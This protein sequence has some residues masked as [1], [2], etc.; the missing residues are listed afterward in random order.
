MKLARLSLIPLFVTI[1]LINQ[2]WLTVSLTMAKPV[3][4]TGSDA[5]SGLAPLVFATILAVLVAI[6]LNG[7]LSVVLIIASETFLAIAVCLGFSIFFQS[8]P[9]FANNAI[10]KTT[11]IQGWSGQIESVVTSWSFTGWQIGT[12]A[13]IVSTAI[14]LALAGLQIGRNQKVKQNPPQKKQNQAKQPDLWSET[15]Q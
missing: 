13:C 1:I 5:L 12:L 3:A 10:A 9:S 6:Y 4:V 7:V 8:D 11:G 14:L 15:S 2:T